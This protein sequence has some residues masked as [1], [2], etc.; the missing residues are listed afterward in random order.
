[1]DEDNPS[2]TVQTTNQEPTPD[3]Y[4]HYDLIMS[5]EDK[6]QPVQVS[7]FTKISFFTG[8]ALFSIFSGLG[9]SVIGARTTYREE[10]EEV[11]EELEKRNGQSKYKGGRRMVHED[12]VLFATRALGWGT[13]I[14]ILGAG[15][16]GLAVHGL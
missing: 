12:P 1:M 6:R 15:A 5:I 16:I 8:C 3:H 10:K 14:G 9:L 11:M 7:K 2:R 13:L 4:G